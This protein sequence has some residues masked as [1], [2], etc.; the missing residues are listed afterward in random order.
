MP[1][2]KEI[3]RTFFRKGYQTT[4]PMLKILLEGDPRYRRLIQL[5]LE[6]REM[7]NGAPFTHTLDY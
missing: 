1:S 7:M 3:F 6:F 2:K 5:C 4:Q